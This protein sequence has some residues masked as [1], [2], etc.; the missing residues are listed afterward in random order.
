MCQLGQLPYSRSI[1]SIQSWTT[2]L[3]TLRRD[4]TSSKA[5][6]LTSMA[7][8]GTVPVTGSCITPKGRSPPFCLHL[9]SAWS[10]TKNRSFRHVPSISP[11][12]CRF[13]DTFGSQ[14]HARQFPVASLEADV[15]PLKSFQ[16]RGPTC[17]GSETRWRVTCFPN[18][19]RHMPGPDP[20]APA[21]HLP[22]P[23]SG[24]GSRSASSCV[25]P[26]RVWLTALSLM[27]GKS[28]P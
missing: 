15:E 20:D 14:Y 10:R 18:S 28:L 16:R 23:R 5:Y 11:R 7:H 13:P 3:S 1:S 19:V 6:P 22:P 4:A 17:S 21:T 27:M 25:L 8:S 12:H 24:R 26:L 2:Y 9:V